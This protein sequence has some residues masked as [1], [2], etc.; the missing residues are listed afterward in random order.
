MTLIGSE[1][2]PIIQPIPDSTQPKELPLE[3][4]NPDLRL[5]NIQDLYTIQTIVQEE[6]DQKLSIDEVLAR[7]LSLYRLYVPFQRVIITENEETTKLDL[8]I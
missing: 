5:Q 4:R 1:V 7:V 2:I 8:I 6:E 3:P